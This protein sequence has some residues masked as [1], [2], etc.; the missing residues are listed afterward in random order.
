MLRFYAV[1]TVMLASRLSLLT[2]AF[3]FRS[4]CGPTASPQPRFAHTLADSPAF[5]WAFPCCGRVVQHATALRLHKPLHVDYAQDDE[6]T[7]ASGAVTVALED[8]AAEVPPA[9]ATITTGRLNCE[10]GGCQSGGVGFLGRSCSTYQR[11]SREEQGP[12]SVGRL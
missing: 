6:P 5:V 9:A 1:L 4:G 10:W 3:L 2:P 7:A 11:G 12:L 8:G